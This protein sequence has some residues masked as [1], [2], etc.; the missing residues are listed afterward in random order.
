MKRHA[1]ATS[2][3]DSKL[4]QKLGNNSSAA[5]T[6]AATAAAAAAAAGMGEKMGGK[7]VGGGG[8]GMKGVIKLEGRENV[9]PGTGVGT[10]RRLRSSPL[11]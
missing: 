3:V 8:G 10:G 2:G 4:P 7:V 11:G 6:R 9:L 1:T 5:A